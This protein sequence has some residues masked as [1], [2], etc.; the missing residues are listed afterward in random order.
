M[1]GNIDPDRE[2]QGRPKSRELAILIWTGSAH[3]HTGPRP[4]SAP[5]SR[6]RTHDM[7]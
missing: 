3:R 5:H 1:I 2:N 6:G 7:V 4:S